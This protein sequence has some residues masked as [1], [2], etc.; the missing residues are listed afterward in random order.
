[1]FGHVEAAKLGTG[2][3]FALTVTIASRP[4]ETRT[5][6]HLAGRWGQ[7]R[8]SFASDTDGHVGAKPEPV[9][10]GA[11]LR[12]ARSSGARALPCRSRSPSSAAKDLCDITRHRSR[13]I[14]HL[15]DG[16]EVFVPMLQPQAI[17]EYGDDHGEPHRCG[18]VCL[19]YVAYAS[20]SG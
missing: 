8:V 16:V 9:P 17:A 12:P 20:S 11:A 3:G 15:L 13:D 10:T 4:D 1:M 7:V 6:P 14:G 5:C 19:Q 18:R 2:S